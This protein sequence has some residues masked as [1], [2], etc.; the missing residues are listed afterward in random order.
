MDS[1]LTNVNLREHLRI[2]SSEKTYHLIEWRLIH[3]PEILKHQTEEEYIFE[4][5]L[6]DEIIRRLVSVINRYKNTMKF[7][8]PK[9]MNLKDPF[10]T[11]T[12]NEK[13]LLEKFVEDE[14]KLK[15]FYEMVKKLGLEICFEFCGYVMAFYLR[16]KSNLK[17]NQQ[18]KFRIF[19]D[20]K[21]I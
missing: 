17:K 6:P 15:Q 1:A 16:G 8:A 21:K 3:N 2:N 9:P 11:L 14:S 19:M 7:Q 10:V 18:K 5:F 12:Q 20:L 13:L 4:S